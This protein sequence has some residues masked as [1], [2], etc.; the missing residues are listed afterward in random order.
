MQRSAS[1][2][3]EPDSTR[4]KYRKA[5]SD[6]YPGSVDHGTD[7]GG[8]RTTY[9]S[10]FLQRHV[11]ADF[12]HTVVRQDHFGGVGRWAK[13]LDVLASGVNAGGAIVQVTA[14][15]PPLA[16]FRT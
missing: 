2:A 4:T 9:Q 10:R 16:Q 7:T 5:R 12:H 11:V 8:H 13:M 6:R 3:R 14:L 15:R 1:C